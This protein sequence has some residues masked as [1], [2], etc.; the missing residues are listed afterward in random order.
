MIYKW[1]EVALRDTHDMLYV[2]YDN[3]IWVHC[4]FFKVATRDDA[5][6]TNI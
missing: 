4:I 6:Q 2:F 3:L 1:V 5:H